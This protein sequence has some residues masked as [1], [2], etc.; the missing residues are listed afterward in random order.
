MNTPPAAQ[1]LVP[2]RIIAHLVAAAKARGIAGAQD[3]AILATLQQMAD[4]L[5]PGQNLFA[6]LF[7][8]PANAEALPP[9]A[10][11]ESFWRE[12][13]TSREVRRLEGSFY[14]PIPVIDAIIDLVWDS[15][16]TLNATLCD[17][18]VGCGFFPLR[19][20][21][22]LL[23]T[24]G[25]TQDAVRRWAAT[26]LF[27]CD[28]DA[29]AVFMSRV[30]V[31]LTL[32]DR[33]GEFVP[34]KGTF[35]LGD[36]LLGRDFL[37][38][39]LHPAT[40]GLDW[41]TAFPSVASAGGFDIVIG[42]PP[43]EVLTNFSRFPERRDLANALRASGNFRDA[44]QGQV[45]LY[46][47]FIERSL[48]LLRP[49]G[50]VSMVA[51]LSL[52]RDKAARPLRERLLR[53]EGAA[54][55][56]LFSERDGLFAG[57][58][59]SACIFLAERDRGRADEIHIESA[60][61]RASLPF[62]QVEDLGDDLLLPVMNDAGIRLWQWLGR[63]HPDT[64]ANH[65]DLRVG[66]VDQTFFRDCMRDADTGCV[67]ARGTHLRAFFLDVSPVPGKERFLDLPRFLAAK[68]RG[69]EDCAA[70]AGTRR[71]VQLGIRNMQSRPRLQAAIAPPGIYLGNSLNVI[72]PKDGTPLEF[73]AGLLNSRL[74]DWLFCH[75]S[76]N[77]NINLH[78]VGSL[79]YPTTPSAS[80]IQNIV[81]AYEHCAA[82]AAAGA[83][84][85]AARER[86]DNQVYECY[87]VPAD[88][89]TALDS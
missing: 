6:D 7:V 17:P 22:R 49:G 76:G 21:D 37:S 57:V 88:L 27:G 16:A 38:T 29:R 15:V 28:C 13:G 77:N 82:S 44:L 40:T 45:N 75:L 47:C 9:R 34:G 8:T 46:R 53:R 70:R 55:W 87:G 39:S 58:T 69:G 42:N 71:I 10:I 2:P 80:A 52:A 89:L 56:R 33:T 3:A 64:I 4:D 41:P 43:Y 48:D 18:A 32:S 66:E 68:G 65:A 11:G 20:L 67:L 5:I 83:D 54:E 51:P 30:L 84:V 78:E 12:A 1:P 60:A 85:E 63:N 26:S 86:L 72:Q 14:T 24:P 35:A 23:D 81:D 62:D 50:L 74:L 73:L 61:G 25:V 19:V 36:S 79:P 31:W 59:Q